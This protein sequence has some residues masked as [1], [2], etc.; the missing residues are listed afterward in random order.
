MAAPSEQYDPQVE[1]LAA[2]FGATATAIATAIAASAA[3]NTASASLDQLNAGISAALTSLLAVS[4]SW[5]NAN[6]P[7][8][9]RNGVQDAL[10]ASETGDGPGRV[11]EAIARFEHRQAISAA[12]NALA[13]ELQGA[14]Q[15]IGQDANVALQ[16]IRRRNVARALAPAEL[17]PLGNALAEDMAG[18]IREG[19]IRFRDRAG[20]KWEAEAYARMVLRTNVATVLNAGHVNAAIELGSSY[21][22]V[23]D[24]GP[25]DVDE[26]CKRA[27]GQVWHIAVAA[28]NMLEHP[29]CR[30]SFAALDPPASLLVDFEAPVSWPMTEFP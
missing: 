5:I 22:R 10:G 28:A 7:N 20:R 13:A 1:T 3:G 11:D 29:N 15:G 2:A 25:G 30:R 6:I 16:E 8:V 17:A 19:G 23:F 21:V 27:N 26:P 24:G 9:Y 4:V 12:Q 14:V 18:Q